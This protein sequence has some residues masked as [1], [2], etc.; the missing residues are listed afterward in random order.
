MPAALAGRMARRRAR[1]PE[2]LMEAGSEEAPI[3]EAIGLLRA[4]LDSL[5]IRYADSTFEG[6][7]VDRVRARITRHMLPDVGRWLGAHTPAT[8]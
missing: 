2:I 4:T 5:A 7:H 3:L 8:H 6:G 1:Q